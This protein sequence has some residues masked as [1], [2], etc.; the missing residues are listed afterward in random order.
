MKTMKDQKDV[1]EMI[2]NIILEKLRQGTVPWMKNWNSFGP[3]RNYV[4]DKPYRGFNALFLGMMGANFD[5]PL[6]ITFNQVKQLGG[7]V[8]KGSKSLPV[9]YWKKL[10]YSSRTSKS[11][12]PEDLKNHTQDE[13]NVIPLLRYY[14]V[15]NIDCT[16][17][18]DFKLPGENF[19]NNPSGLCEKI[20]SGMPNKPEIVFGGDQPYY[21]A[22]TDTV[23]IPHINNFTSE[24]EYYAAMFHELSHS[25]G[26]ATRL[27]RETLAQPAFYASEAYCMEE[28]VA[29]IAA[30]FICHEAGIVDKTIDN[31]ASYIGFWQDSLQK[32]LNG[33]QE[34]F[35]KGIIGRSKGR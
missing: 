3:A 13:I 11:I 8:K 32:I 19:I 6:F 24:A 10:Y 20:V 23:K 9:I 35:P 1:Y 31:S 34:V 5:Y 17:G 22:A 30:C 18:I 33:R 14:S 16:E 15:F 2:N 12:R 27:N 29:E 4:T 28:L 25:T 7:S 21:N 26:H